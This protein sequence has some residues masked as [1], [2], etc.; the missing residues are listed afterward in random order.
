MITTL[1]TVLQDAQRRHYAVGAFNTN[2]LEFSQAIIEAATDERSPVIIQLSPKALTYGAEALV[3]AVRLLAKAAPVPVVIH[4]DHGKSVADVE[5]ALK[6]GFSSVMIDGSNLSFQKNVSL[7][8]KVMKICKRRVSVEAELGTIGGQED[9]I[10]G[11]QLSYP[12]VDEVKKFVNETKVQALAIGLGTSHGLPIKHEH[13][14][15]ELL[16]QIR[17]VCR[18]PLVLHGASNIAPI[19]IR[20]AILHGIT[21]INIDTELRQVFTGAVRHA[22]TSDMKQFDVRVYLGAAKEA[23]KARV[24][25]KMRLFGS[26]GKATYAYIHIR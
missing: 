11:R 14:E 15:H 8:N 23:T 5:M 18:T 22:L 7:V 2:N 4:L 1:K 25:Q 3:V 10:H 16:R 9:Y 12:S 13:I 24:A 26:T 21:K 20:A 17:D 6:W 19:T